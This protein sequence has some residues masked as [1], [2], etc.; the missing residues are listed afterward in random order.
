MWVVVVVNEGTF[1]AYI[2]GELTNS[3]DGFPD[4]FTPVGGNSSFALA[5]NLF[6][7]DA[8]FNG[9]MDELVIFDDPISI[10]DVQELYA[11]GSSQ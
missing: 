9:K 10:D 11:E 3:L 6:P 2:N 8:N 4:V 7:W 5:T 1:N